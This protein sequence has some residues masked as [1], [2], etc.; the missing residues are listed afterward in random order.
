[1]AINPLKYITKEELRDLA[2]VS[3]DIFEFSKEVYVRHP[4]RGKV[5]FILYPFQ[6]LVVWYFLTKRF[7]IIKKFRQAGITEL[8]AMFCLWLAMYHPNKN[9]QIISIKDRVAKRV[10]DKIKYMYKNLP[11]HLKTPIV[12][13]RGGEMGTATEIEFSN[14]SIIVSVPTTEDAGRSEGLSLLVIDEAAI[15]R[16]AS[17]IWASAFPTLSTGG[18]AI[19]NSTPFGTSNWY[20]STWVDSFVGDNPFN[21]INLKWTMH[22]ERDMK[23]YNEMRT[24]LGT[25]RT[26]QEIDGDFLSS[27]DSVF[28]L[29]DIKAIEDNLPDYPPIERRFN[30]NLLIFK[31]PRTGVQYFIGADVSSGR[32]RDYSAFNVM[33]AH[34]E[35]YAAFKGKIP[36]NRL[37]DMLMAIGT[38]YNQATLAPEG[39]DIGLSTVHRIQDAGYPELYYTMQILKEKG[40]SQP[41]VESV[42]GWLTTSKNRPVIIDELE[43]DVR[44]ESIIIK[45]PFF[46]HEGYTFIYNSVNK[47]IASGKDKKRGTQEEELDDVADYTDDSII[48]TAITNHIRKRGKSAVILPPQ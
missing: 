11:N 18:S 39:N 25:K 41:Q 33:D 6:R 20:Y 5:K 45:N 26:A 28:D 15:I 36:P 8:I 35:E 37:A 48:S 47:A 29:S 1:M 42:P 3:K 46:V 22:P 21:A 9:I 10:L 44:T 17:K 24:V 7:N 23:W 27:G 38:E 13:G 14:G 43:T 2:R 30:G 32:S 16:Y 31:R 19:V 12:N 34:G 4:V 40:K